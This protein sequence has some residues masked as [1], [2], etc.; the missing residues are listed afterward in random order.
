MTVINYYSFPMY[1]WQWR[2]QRLRRNRYLTCTV[3][4]KFAFTYTTSS[5]NN[6]GIHAG[7]CC[8]CKNNQIKLSGALY[9]RYDNT[10]QTTAYQIHLYICRYMDRLIVDG[11]IVYSLLIL[12]Y[13]YVCIRG[14]TIYAIRIQYN[15]DLSE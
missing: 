14:L 2:R 11:C 1:Q 4:A 13:Y 12:N 8:V 5:R 9:N 15:C 6:N 10:L 7:V 3:D